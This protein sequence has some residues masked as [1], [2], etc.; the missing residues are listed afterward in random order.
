MRFVALKAAAQIGVQVLH[1]VR[2][3]LTAWRTSL[4]NQLRSI[5]LERRISV[6]PGRRNL[7]DALAALVDGAEARGSVHKCG[8]CLKT[9]LPVAR[10]R[11][12]IT[13]L[14]DCSPRWRATTRQ[15]GDPNS[16]RSR[17]PPFGSFVVGRMWD[18]RTVFP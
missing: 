13:V 10:A 17:W 15:R 4:T 1:R 12:R 11:R 5:L 7:L 8:F 18:V 3:R 9:C 6:A 16:I 2:D 14:Y